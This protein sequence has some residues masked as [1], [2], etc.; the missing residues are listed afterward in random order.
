MRWKWTLIVHNVM[1]LNYYSLTKPVGIFQLMQGRSSTSINSTNEHRFK[2][3]KYH[4]IYWPGQ[5]IDQSFT[6]FYVKAYTIFLIKN[7][8]TLNKT[9]AYTW[10]CSICIFDHMPLYLGNSTD[11]IGCRKSCKSCV[12]NFCWNLCSIDG[13]TNSWHY[14]P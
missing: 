1:N 4:P 3:A 8:Y 11:F 9:I 5:Y 7:D 10:S 13:W 12:E 2:V 6:P 14:F